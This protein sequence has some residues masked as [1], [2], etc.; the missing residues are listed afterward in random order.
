MKPTRAQS[1][2]EAILASPPIKAHS[3]ASVDALIESPHE[4]SVASAEHLPPSSTGVK[5]FGDVDPG[6]PTACKPA[7]EIGPLLIAA[8]PSS[9]GEIHLNSAALV[10][11]AQGPGKLLIGSADSPGIIQSAAGPEIPMIVRATPDAQGL[12]QGWGTI[13]TGGELINNGKIVA[14]GYGHLRSLDLS[15]FSSVSNTIDN[16][17]DGTNGWYAENGASLTLPP[18]AVAPG[19]HTYTWGENPLDP[20]L[21]LVNS[22]RFTV[23]DQ[24]TPAKV[25]IT[26]KSPQA[27]AAEIAQPPGNVKVITEWE[28]DATDLNSQ[29][30]QF[31]TRYR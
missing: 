8:A 10:V 18:I 22:V 7:S 21:D 20:T 1:F 16:P 14:D 5:F 25:S 4:I 2:A 3:A 31:A 27:A 19:T 11:G 24:P 26:L 29:L 13:S 17:P 23:H 12:V 6:T 30:I 9:S 28:F 15:D